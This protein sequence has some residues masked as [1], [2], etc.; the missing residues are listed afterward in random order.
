MSYTW[1]NKTKGTNCSYSTCS[2]LTTNYWLTDTTTSQ[3]VTNSNTEENVE[4]RDALQGLVGAWGKLQYNRLSAS[5]IGD[6]N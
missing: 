5:P 6:Q 3:S 1:G 4:G 2:A